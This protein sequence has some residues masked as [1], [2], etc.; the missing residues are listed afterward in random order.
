MSSEV[1]A[2]FFAVLM[3]A[4]RPWSA[5]PPSGGNAP[6]NMSSRRSISRRNAASANA[7]GLTLNG[8]P[9]QSARKA[10]TLVAVSG[11]TRKDNG[12]FDDR[13]RAILPTVVTG[14]ATAQ[15]RSSGMRVIVVNV[16]A[17]YTWATPRCTAMTTLRQTSIRRS[18][19]GMVPH[20]ARWASAVSSAAV[21]GR[22]KHAADRVRR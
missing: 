4:L 6:A 15:C 13:E 21:R 7:P 11:L 19:V 16:S 14:G 10:R 17:P 3:D 8:T 20:G 18:P 9:H 1:L 5:S 22:N 12:T 2:F